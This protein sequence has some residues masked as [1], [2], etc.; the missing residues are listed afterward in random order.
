MS[1]NT[2][3]EDPRVI[4]TKK[5]LANALLELI[6]EKNFDS[7]SIGDITERATLNRATFYLHYRDKF[8]LLD[9]IMKT[10]HEEITN[11]IN[12]YTTY[13]LE[14]NSLDQPP[15]AMIEWFKHIGKHANYYEVMLG[16]NGIKTFSDEISHYLEEFLLTWLKMTAKKGNKLSAPID[17]A[18]CYLA[19]A[20][21]GLISW[22]LKNNQPY[23]PEEISSM[24]WKLIVNG[25]LEKP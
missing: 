15:L 9:A 16:K 8:D 4:R 7:I 3:P 6:A 12:Y 14:N 1:I 11:R 24:L 25:P 22:W 20:Y 21:L 13:D 17:I 5:M 10:M 23:S 19:N 18:S 2:A